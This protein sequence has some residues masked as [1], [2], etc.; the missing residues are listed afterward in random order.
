MEQIILSITNAF[1]YALLAIGLATVLTK[2]SPLL[3]SIDLASEVKQGNAAVSYFAAG[4]F[5]LI[6]LVV[7]FVAIA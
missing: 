5:V 6:G 3:F 2:M 1:L 4:L 7:G